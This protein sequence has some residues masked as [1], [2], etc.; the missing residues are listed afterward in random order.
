[1]RLATTRFFSFKG[2]KVG[3]VAP[4]R[5]IR[6]T[7]VRHH[8]SAVVRLATTRFFSFKGKRLGRLLRADKFD[9]HKFAIICLLRCASPRRD[10]SRLNNLLAV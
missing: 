2:E 5:Q 9:E 4:R 10:F 3:V 8:L 1:V 6:R 7:Q